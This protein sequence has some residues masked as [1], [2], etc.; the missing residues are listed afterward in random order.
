MMTPI[1]GATAFS[2]NSKLF[3]SVAAVHPH[4][5]NTLTVQATLDGTPTELGDWILTNTQSVGKTVSAD[6]EPGQLVSVAVNISAND[7]TV[8]G[9]ISIPDVEITANGTNYHYPNMTIPAASMKYNSS[10][11]PVITFGDWDQFM[12]DVEDYRFPATG[13]CLYRKSLDDIDF[14]LLDSFSENPVTYTDTTALPN[15][16]YRYVIVG[17]DVLGQ[18][19]SIAIFI[20][21]YV[22]GKSFVEPYLTLLPRWT[23]AR[24]DPQDAHSAVIN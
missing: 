12:P 6:Y 5:I 4:Y 11:Q 19:R 1:F 7:G 21:G 3:V 23:A 24:I 2:Y 10:Y 18:R 22:V 8:T 15:T 16:S 17:T 14:T 20:S 9:A 13:F